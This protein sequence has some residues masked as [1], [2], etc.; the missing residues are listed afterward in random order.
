MPK[1]Y[2]GL[3]G[4][5]EIYD[6]SS[7]LHKKMNNGKTESRIYKNASAIPSRQDRWRIEQ[8]IRTSY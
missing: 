2:F 8:M 7:I 1:Y 3:D 6:E 4:K 5:Y